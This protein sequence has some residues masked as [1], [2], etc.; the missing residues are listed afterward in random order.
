[1]MAGCAPESSNSLEMYE[2]CISSVIKVLREGRR[3]GAKDFFFT[4]DLDVELGMMCTDEKDTEELM[5][6]YCPLC[7][8]GHDK[9]PG[10]LQETDVVWD[11]E[12]SSTQLQG[13]HHMVRVRKGG[14][15]QM[16]SRTDIWSREKK[17]ETSQLDYI[18][19]PMRRNDEVYIH[20]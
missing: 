4:G 12:R 2:A 8:Q 1:M 19:G 15:E 6:M 5:G 18:I 7:W 16:P 10:V 3:G 17:E 14:Q 20:K 13:H 9:V 11:C